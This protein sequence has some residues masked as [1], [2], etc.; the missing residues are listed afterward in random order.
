MLAIPSKCLHSQTVAPCL[1]MVAG[2]TKAMKITVFLKFDGKVVKFAAWA[3]SSM[4]L[5]R[6]QDQKLF[7]LCMEQ[8]ALSDGTRLQAEVNARLDYQMHGQCS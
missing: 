4:E 7:E 1:S 5:Y 8:H 3:F 6:M 2:H